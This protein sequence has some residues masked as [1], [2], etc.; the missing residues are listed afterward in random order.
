[1]E[2]DAKVKSTEPADPAALIA[3][4]LKRKFAHRYRHNSE[5]E[6]NED[7]QL[8]VRDMKPQTETP[9]VRNVSV[10]N[11]NVIITLLFSQWAKDATILAINLALTSALLLDLLFCDLVANM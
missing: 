8:P 7:F 2:A 6:D 5:R 3:E 4:A 9:L 10:F 11:I 1:M